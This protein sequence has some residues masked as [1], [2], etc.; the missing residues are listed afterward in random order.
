[1]TVPVGDLVVS[2]EAL[3]FAQRAV[4]SAANFLSVRARDLGGDVAV[5]VIDGVGDFS[6]GAHAGK[7]CEM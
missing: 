7:K 2:T 6:E 5:V 4:S 3:I 1:M